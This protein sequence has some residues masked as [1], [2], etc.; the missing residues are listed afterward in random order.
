LL[1]IDLI[2]NFNLPYFSQNPSEFWRRW[3]IS[4][5]SWLRDYLYISL[6]GNR[7]GST[8][9][10]LMLTM[11]LGGLWHGAAWNYVLW[12]A[13]QGSLLCVHRLAI[14]RGASSPFANHTLM[15]PVRIGFF[16]LLTCYG[17]LLF[18]ARTFDQ[19]SSF[20]TTLLGF[21]GTVSSTIGRPATSAILGMA[22]LAALQVCDYRAHKLE[23]FLSWRPSLQGLLYAALIF[24]L[25]MGMSNAPA[26]FIY[27]Q[28]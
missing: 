6:G 18:R 28:F 13:Y 2:V 17:W 20:T 21:D 27:F 3:H 24:I 9:V 11:L 25:A 12:G 22:L 26:Q 23:S 7:R 4:L 16:F 10:N 19:I 1:G 15:T 5:S 14:G 8:Y